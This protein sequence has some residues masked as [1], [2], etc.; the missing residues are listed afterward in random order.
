MYFD[1]KLSLQEVSLRKEL[2]QMVQTGF[3]FRGEALEKIKKLRLYRDTYNSF[4]EYCEDVFGFTKLY[5]QRCLIAVQTH[6]NIED[7]IKT[8]GLNCP[9]PTK[10]R[11][12]RPIFQSD[13]APIET[14]EVWVMAVNLNLG[15]VPPSRLVKEAVRSY[16][17]QKYPTVSSLQRDQPCKILSG[18]PGK[19][20][21]WCLVESVEGDTVTVNTWDNEY[22]V[23]SDDLEPLKIS[24][25]DRELF[26]E[27]GER[28]SRLFSKGVRDEAA[29]WVLHGLEKLKR[30][31]L[32]SLEEKLLKVIE[33]E[34]G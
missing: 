10:Q 5:I 32:T 17:K 20:G 2:E 25:V 13:L 19:T 15:K 6:R 3:L 22:V 33:E 24:P 11:Q 9:L 1:F 23:C 31:R 16:L 34:L 14:G 26:F 29:Y 18:V 8:N 7:Y 30:S 27:L 12:L 21:C 4:D 28:M